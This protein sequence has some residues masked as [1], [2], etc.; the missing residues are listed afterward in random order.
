MSDSAIVIH[1]SASQAPIPYAVQR[2]YLL[3]RGARGAVALGLMVVA[4]VALQSPLLA[5]FG[6]FMV[7][8]LMWGGLRYGRYGRGQRQERRRYAHRVAGR[9]ATR[10]API[11]VAE[12]AEA[13]SPAADS[14][15]RRAVLALTA[16]ADAPLYQRARERGLSLVDKLSEMEL[17]LDDGALNA[18]LRQPLAD[19]RADIESELQALLSALSRA[20][21]GRRKELTDWFAAQ[22]EV[23][24]IAPAYSS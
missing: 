4:A 20:A 6:L 2:H 15:N 11:G 23:E 18:S 10:Y 13:A 5:L 22:A 19:R 12:V 16:E 8:R 9:S 1:A 3:R 17:L 14:P 24:A 21:S 7:R